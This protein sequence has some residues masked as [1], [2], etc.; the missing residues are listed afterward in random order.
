[1]RPSGLMCMELSTWKAW[2]PLHSLFGAHVSKVSP[3]GMAAL[4]SEPAA[5]P[6]DCLSY[7]PLSCLV[8]M[9]GL[10][11][12]DAGCSCGLCIS[13]RHMASAS[14]ME[15]D[16]EQDEC[17]EQPLGRAYRAA[18]AW[19][20]DFLVTQASISVEGLETDR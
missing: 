2:G 15:L 13:L 7:R 20:P 14:G 16:P 12:V 11:C 10:T 19:W 17:P 4:K 18:W 5:L 8:L 9:V 6:T 1:M 3:Q